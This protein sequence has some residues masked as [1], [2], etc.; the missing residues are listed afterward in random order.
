[1][2][3]LFPARCIGSRVSNMSPTVHQMRPFLQTSHAALPSAQRRMCEPWGA[4]LR[5]TQALEVTR[6]FFLRLPY[7]DTALKA[8]RL[9]A[10]SSLAGLRIET[11]FV[12]FSL[13]VEIKNGG[14]L[15]TECPDDVKA[16]CGKWAF[17]NV[18]V[19]HVW[20][21]DLEKHVNLE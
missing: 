7:L 17:P 2:Y 18:P 8:T 14:L 5:Q 3:F 13:L 1:M 20:R 4:L 11:T 10:N 12:H 15:S 19:G 6:H 9:S 16:I 21:F